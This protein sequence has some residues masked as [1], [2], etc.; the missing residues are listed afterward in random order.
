MTSK[1]YRLFR[2]ESS[3]FKLS[4]LSAGHFFNDLYASFLPTFIPN[5]FPGWDSPCPGRLF[6]H[7]PRRDPYHLPACHRLPFRPLGQPVAHNLGSL[8]HLFRSHHDPPV[9]HLRNGSLFRRAVGL[10][11]AMFHPRGT[12][13]WDTWFP[14]TG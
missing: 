7:L 5:S 6:Q 13:E 8:P 9:A 10:G 4:L 12:A 1:T 2:T 3:G 11:S 14:G